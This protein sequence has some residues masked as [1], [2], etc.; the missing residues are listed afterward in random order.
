MTTVAGSHP[1][2]TD[3]VVERC[4]VARVSSLIQAMKLSRQSKAL[5]KAPAS[6]QCG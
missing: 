4:P 5:E 1:Y 2:T 3:D 6:R